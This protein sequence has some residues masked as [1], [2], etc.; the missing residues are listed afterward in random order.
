M[1]QLILNS[2]LRT[3]TFT[4]MGHREIEV[5]IF[6]VMYVKIDKIIVGVM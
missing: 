1:P 4:E 2:G 5:L 6:R 3:E